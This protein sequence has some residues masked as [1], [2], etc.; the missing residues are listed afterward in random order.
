M[1]IDKFKTCQ[2]CP[3]RTIHPNC[4][5]ICEGYLYRKMQIDKA[6]KARQDRD[7]ISFLS[8]TP[9][10]YSLGKGMSKRLWRVYHTKENIERSRNQ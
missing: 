2:N 4:H 9:G 6:N 3:D 8:F 1:G 7:R 5:T 10:C